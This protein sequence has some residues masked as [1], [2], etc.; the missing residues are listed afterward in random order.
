VIPTAPV[1]A[2]KASAH[3]RTHIAAAGLLALLLSPNPGNAQ[4]QS[5]WS[6]RPRTF[7]GDC[8]EVCSSPRLRFGAR[9]MRCRGV[10]RA[11]DERQRDFSEKLTLRLTVN[12]THRAPFTT[13]NTRERPVRTFFRE[14]DNMDCRPADRPSQSLARGEPWTQFARSW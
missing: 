5:R 11:F 12:A 3:D 1:D 4:L 6:N 9:A 13:P 2:K 8:S 14:S 10:A 7:N